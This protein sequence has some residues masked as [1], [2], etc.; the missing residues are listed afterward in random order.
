MSGEKPS[1]FPAFKEVFTTLR[2]LSEEPLFNRGGGGDS[3]LQWAETRAYILYIYIYA[4]IVGVA[5]QIALVTM[6]IS[7][8]VLYTA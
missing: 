6:T 2:V 1:P 5:Q 3:I 8:T 7:Y 4:K